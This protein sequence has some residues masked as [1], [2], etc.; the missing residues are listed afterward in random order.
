M[1]FQ[2]GLRSRPFLTEGF[3]ERVFQNVYN[4]AH[5][6]ITSALKLIISRFVKPNIDK[7][8]FNGRVHVFSVKKQKNIL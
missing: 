2:L 3:Q 6:G 5:H 1:T 4:L 7:I 8:I